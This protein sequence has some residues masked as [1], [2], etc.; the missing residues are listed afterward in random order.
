MSCQCGKSF[1]TSQALMQHTRDSPRHRQSTM[2]RLSASG[3]GTF[4]S[5]EALPQH[6]RDLPIPLG[7]NTVGCTGLLKCSCGKTVKDENGLKDVTASLSKAAENDEEKSFYGF[8]DDGM[9]SVTSCSI[10]QRIYADY[11]FTAQLLS[12]G[13]RLTATRRRDRFKQAYY[14]RQGNWHRARDQKYRRR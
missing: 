2:S 13:Q 4:K 9:V 1:K 3:K 6:Q 12:M 5:E 11:S 14:F 7:I 8:P 10:R